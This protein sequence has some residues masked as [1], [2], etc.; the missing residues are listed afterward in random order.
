MSELPPLPPELEK[1]G[2]IVESHKT[3]DSLELLGKVNSV[4]ESL[5]FLI[6]NSEEYTQNLQRILIQVDTYKLRELQKICK[7]NK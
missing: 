2:D 1:F 5:T 3:G 7:E 6:R 4:I